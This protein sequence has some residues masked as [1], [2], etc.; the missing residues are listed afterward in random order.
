MKKIVSGMMLVL[1]LTGLLMLAF[2]VRT[3]N[4]QGFWVWVR[5]TVTGAY[6]EAVIG[7]G[8]A[9]YIAR[10]KSFYCYSP[11][12]NTF[13]KLADP[14][15][16][17]GSAFKTGTALAWDFG[18]YI[19]ALYGA[20]TGDSRRYFYRYS[21][22]Q[23]LWE[24]LADTPF[25]QGE[26][27]AMTYVG[28]IGVYATAGGEQRQTHLLFYNS[29]T[30]SWEPQFPAPMPGM[31]DGASMVWTGSDCLYIL[32]GEYLEKEPIYDFWQY[33]ITS[34]ALTSLADIPAY[35][36]DGG[37]G[38]VGD[39]GSLLYVGFWLSNQTDYIYALSGNQAY[40]E[41][42]PDNRFYQYVISNNSWTRLADLPF[43]VGYY[44][45]NRLGYADG[46]I[47]TWQGTPSTWEGGGDDLVRYE[48][49]APTEVEVP[50]FKLLNKEV[51][52]F[53]GGLNVTL[54]FYNYGYNAMTGN[55]WLPWEKVFCSVSFNG[56]PPTGILNESLLTFDVNGDGDLIDSFTVQFIDNETVAIDGVTAKALMAPEERVY[57]DSI[58]LY[59]IMEMNSFQLGLKNHT[60]YRVNYRTDIGVGYAGFGLDSFFRYHPS[61][62]MLF[63][64]ENVGTSIN[65]ASRAQITDV[66]INGIPSLLDF[67]WTSPWPDPV[68]EG[69]WYVDSAYVYPTGFISSN[70]TF[71]VHLSIKGEV[72]TYLLITIINWS[73]DSIHRYRYLVIDAVEI[74]FAIKGTVHRTITY[75]N[76]EFPINIVTNSTISENIILNVTAKEICFNA[77]GY[78]ALTFFWNITIPQ[79]LLA[80]NPWTITIDGTSV[81]YTSTTNGSHTFLFFKYTYNEPYF[82]TR[83]ISIIGT[84]VIPEFPS[85]MIPPLFMLTASIVTVLLKKK[86]EAKPQLP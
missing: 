22:S 51:E 16:P 52:G 13:V 59:D 65:S 80:D 28:G 56:E 20:A 82:K 5:D 85:I 1:L 6:G 23:N 14:P 44:V 8:D 43:G 11:S 32:R 75:E 12:D 64:I 26:G 76:E 86:R 55:V 36:H 60:L 41:S 68:I 66:E 71:T 54:T 31:G 33:N 29:S 34:H 63:I 4:A 58:G 37:V 39:G 84:Q 47:Y 17:D 7:T 9:I 42:I 62:N 35:P 69:Q 83:R 48:F 70:S 79:N 45:G 21:I 49:S 30:N 78:G 3:A 25:D 46:H 73:P 61:P 10:G 24:R 15:A 50:L 18:D 27:D 53:E 19:Y 67:N 57:Y 40:P 74:P 72:G 2:D 77:T 81:P 38:G